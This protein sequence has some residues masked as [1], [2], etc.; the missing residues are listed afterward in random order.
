[1]DDAHSVGRAEPRL[2]ARPAKESAMVE[3]VAKRLYEEIHGKLP[4]P[5]P[6]EDIWPE[7]KNR[8]RDVAF[9]AIEEMRDPTEPMIDAG[10]NASFEPRSEVQYIGTVMVKDIW[11][12]M[13]D[14]A[15]K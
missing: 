8:Y 10:D 13:I 6:W 2:R 3:R 9:A 4:I 7:L 12:A 1:M 11:R 15:L 14:E 5:S